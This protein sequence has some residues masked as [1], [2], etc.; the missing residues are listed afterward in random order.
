MNSRQWVLWPS[1]INGP[2]RL[3]QQFGDELVF[4]GGYVL[5]PVHNI[6]ASVPP[7]NVIALFDAALSAGLH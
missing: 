2:T 4:W 6:Q 1:T 3:K 7:E 5:A